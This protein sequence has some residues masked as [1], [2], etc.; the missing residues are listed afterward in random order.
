[1]KRKIYTIDGSKYSAKTE[2]ITMRIVPRRQKDPL[3]GTNRPS[4]VAVTVNINDEIN[5]CLIQLQLS[6]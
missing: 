3:S 5:L 4:D 6:P 2:C 1:V